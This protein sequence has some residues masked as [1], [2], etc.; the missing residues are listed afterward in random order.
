[1]RI[2]NENTNKSELNKQIKV[3]MDSKEFR[4]KVEKIVKERL[5]D[6]KELEEY[7]LDITK[8]AMTQLFKTLWVKR[9]TWKNNIKNT[10]N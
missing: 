1:M 4:D 9:N 8:N 6:N 10:S 5:K 3:Y 7:T 2:I